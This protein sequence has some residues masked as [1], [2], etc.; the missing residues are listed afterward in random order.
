ML[1]PDQVDAFLERW[2][3]VWRQPTPE[4]V[5]DLLAPEVRLVQPLDG[6][7]HGLEKTLGMWRRL[8]R[9]IPDLRAEVLTS[10][11]S[12]RYVWIELRMYGTL[13]G[14]PVEWFVA[15]RVEL[16]PDGRVSERIAYFDPLQLFGALLRNPRGLVRFLR[17]RLAG[18]Q[19]LSR[20][21]RTSRP[22]HYAPRPR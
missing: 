8:F 12:D 19:P 10:A 9:T 4:R 7:L 17:V 1:G 13:E 22:R 2:A 16:A 11:T 15:N 20:R 3:D 6:E 14:K 5:N 21:R 18:A